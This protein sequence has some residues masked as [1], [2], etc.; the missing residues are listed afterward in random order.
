VSS[1]FS[2]VRFH[3]ISTQGCFSVTNCLTLPLQ[4]PYVTE[5]F[6]HR[7]FLKYFIPMKR[8]N[9]IQGLGLMGAT[10]L[11]SSSM[12]VS[13][14]QGAQTPPHTQPAKSGSAKR[15]L[16]VANLTDIHIRPDKIAEYGMA[17][18]LNAVNAMKDKPDFVINGG[19]SIMNAAV[20][21]KG[22][23]QNQWDTFNSILK[24]DNSLPIHHCL[25]N[26][27]LF[28]W[29]LPSADKTENKKWALDEYKM[30][31]RYY[32]FA[33]NGWKFIVLDSIHARESVPGYFGKLDDEQMD[34]LKQ[35]L[36][37]TTVET[38][39]CIVSH[40]P[41]LAICCLFDGGILNS[42]HRKVSDNNM[43]A[44][45]DA[46]VELFY[47]YPNVRACLSGHI[48][49]IDYVN[50]LGIEFFCNG[51]VAG[52]WWKGDH[53]HFAPSFSVL[54]FFEDGTVTREVEYYKW[55]G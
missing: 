51:A 11:I 10:S 1:F 41:I 40:I 8:F 23:I 26:H 21:T 14:T 38:N 31:S 30:Q 17:A 49:L 24:N 28:G 13:Y 36:K 7:Y 33:Q 32:S 44:D 48:H 27:D 29:L 16:R 22:N 2:A 18:A 42:D 9:F 20:L 35:E 39:I 4:L 19:D 55:K 37:N 50:Y 46:L 52:S 12:P 15:V 5:T 53:Q 45:A 3:V 25:G 47:R 43:H 34:W 54:N 6:L